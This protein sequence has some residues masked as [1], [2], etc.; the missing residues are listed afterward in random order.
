MAKFFLQKFQYD[1]RLPF[2]GEMGTL[3]VARR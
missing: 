2:S 3:E 1:A